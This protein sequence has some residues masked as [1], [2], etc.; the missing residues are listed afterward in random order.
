MSG[1][2]KELSFDSVGKDHGKLIYNYASFLL[3]MV[4][5]DNAPCWLYVTGESLEAKD[6]GGRARSYCDTMT[7]Q[8]NDPFYVSV[9]GSMGVTDEQMQSMF[10]FNNMALRFSF[11]PINDAL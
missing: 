7:R 6:F 3:V 9:V 11:A 5:A 4:L 2:C 8:S 1:S 10:S